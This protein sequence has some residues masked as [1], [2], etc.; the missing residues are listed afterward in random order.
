MKTFGAD[1]CGNKL[2]TE[3]INETIAELSSKG[4]GTLYFPSGTYLTGPIKLKS[5]ITIELEAGAILLFSD[6]FDD[7]LPFV[8]MRHEGVVM[9]SFSPLF[10]AVEEETSQ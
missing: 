10:Y 1:D 3:L 5:N 6:N 4:G 2:N 7:Y 9:K 8:E